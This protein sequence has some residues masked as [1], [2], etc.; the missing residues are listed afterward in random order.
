MMTDLLLVCRSQREACIRLT[1][2]VLRHGAWLKRD[3]AAQ[4]L[5]KI[6]Q[7]SERVFVVGTP[8]TLRFPRS[9]KRR[10]N[11]WVQFPK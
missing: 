7:A 6:A 2:V 11:R 9:S 3:R 10:Y 4:A 8:L 5:D 1:A